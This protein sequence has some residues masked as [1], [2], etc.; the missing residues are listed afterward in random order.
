MVFVIRPIAAPCA[1]MVTAPCTAQGI[2]LAQALAPAHQM[3][4]IVPTMCRILLVATVAQTVR[5]ARVVAVT[6]EAQDVV[7][8]VVADVVAAIDVA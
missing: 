4:L 5:L 7:V 3:A 2:F 8:V 6:V 1:K